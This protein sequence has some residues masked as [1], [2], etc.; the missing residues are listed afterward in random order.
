MNT[1]ASSKGTPVPSNRKRTIQ[2]YKAARKTEQDKFGILETP[3]LHPQLKQYRQNLNQLSYFSNTSHPKESEVWSW[4]INSEHLKYIK[5]RESLKILWVNDVCDL[6]SM[7]DKL[8]QC[9]EIGIDTEFDNTLF[10]HDMISLIQISTHNE[11]FLI[12]PFTVYPYLKDKLQ[13]ILLDENIVK[14]FFGLDDIYY[15]K[16]DF[17][18]FVFPVVDLQSLYMSFKSLKSLKFDQL[19]QELLNVSLD[20][21]YQTY[22]FS[23]RALPLELQRYAADDATYCLKCW[24][25]LKVVI[26]DI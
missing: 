25:T 10:F 11:V 13:P 19:V 2:D 18:M 4:E 15:F 17:E 26:G 21:T 20:K 14:V 12:N 5:S 1:D 8:A 9:Q 7:C 3:Y 16:R 6:F 23:R 22:S 24:K